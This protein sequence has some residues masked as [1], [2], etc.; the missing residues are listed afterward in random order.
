MKIEA[1]DTRVWLSINREDTTKEEYEEL[2]LLWSEEFG[3]KF[4]AG[5]HTI[6]G[7]YMFTEL[8]TRRDFFLSAM[9]IRKAE[10]LGF[11]VS[12]DNNRFGRF[13]LR[14]SPEHFWKM[15]ALAQMHR[16]SS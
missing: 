7:P 3:K 14:T 16:K 15:M 1:I 9:I 11:D 13:S 8:A 6:S 12:L 4:S 2:V 5:L 10:K